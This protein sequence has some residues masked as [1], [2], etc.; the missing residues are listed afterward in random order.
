[1]RHAD[2]I[3]RLA[4]CSADRARAL[5]SHAVEAR[6]RLGDDSLL[7]IALNLGETPVPY[8]SDAGADRTRLLFE[9]PGA[10]HGL[11][12]GVLPGDGLIALLTVSAPAQA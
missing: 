10:A 7:T 3:P 4:G 12:H 8:Q 2:I 1:V 11:D 9:T 5:G 6:W